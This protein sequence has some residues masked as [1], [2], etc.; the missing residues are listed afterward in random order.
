[1]S[2]RRAVLTLLPKIRD[3]TE[4]EKLVSCLV[5][6]HRLQ[7]ALKCIGLQTGERVG[8]GRNMYR[9]FGVPGRS[10]YTKFE[11]FWR[12]S[13]LNIGII[14]LDQEKALDHGVEH[15]L[16]VECSREFWVGLGFISIA[17]VY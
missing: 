1:M 15:R 2:C 16:P 3:L 11:M 12:L 5:T 7:T 17:R 14:F 13:G 6:E 4:L 9:M 8:A 10:I